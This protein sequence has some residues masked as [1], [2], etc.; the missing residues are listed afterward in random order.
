MF[1]SL[2]RPI[3]RHRLMIG[4]VIIGLVGATTTLASFADIANTTVDF[5]Q[6]TNKIAPGI[7]SSNPPSG[8]NAGSGPMYAGIQMFS[9]GG[10]F[11]TFGGSYVKAE[12]RLGD[13]DIYAAS[14]KNI[15]MINKSP[16]VTQNAL[17]QLRGFSG[18]MAEV[19][20]TS[21]DA[22]FAPPQGKAV[23]GVKRILEY[24]LPPASVTTFVLT[25][26]MSAEQVAPGAVLRP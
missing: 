2:L 23:F 16:T 10:Y 20:Q 9:G 19:W 15:V 14:S 13:V 1:T 17:V 22:P 6:T 8:R 26:G 4:V 12:T 5:G 7:F 11:R 21:G 24:P 25:E 3:R 18:G